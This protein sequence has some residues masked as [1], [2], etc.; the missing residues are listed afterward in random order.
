MSGAD[1]ILVG[2]ST[3]TALCAVVMVIVLATAPDDLREVKELLTEILKKIPQDR[4][5]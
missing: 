4:R 1:A 2:T 5:P 3:F